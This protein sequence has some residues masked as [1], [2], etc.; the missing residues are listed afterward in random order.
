MGI[1]V[2][3]ALRRRKQKKSKTENNLSRKLEKGNARRVKSEKH[4]NT[5]IITIFRLFSRCHC[6][7]CS[8][9][10]ALLSI[11]LSVPG[12]AAGASSCPPSSSS[13]KWKRINELG[14]C[15]SHLAGTVA[16]RDTLSL[17]SQLIPAEC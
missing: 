6:S 10:S 4:L 2:K 14:E 3:Y 16:T 13:F 11:S 9:E 17:V 15:W 12:N 8:Y 7:Y 5:Y 1:K